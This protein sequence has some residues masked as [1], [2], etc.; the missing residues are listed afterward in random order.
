[1][2]IKENKNK[3]NKKLFIIFLKKRKKLVKK[4]P[5]L[6]VIDEGLTIKKILLIYLSFL[7]FELL[8]LFVTGNM[9][10]I[11]NII[12]LVNFNFNLKDMKSN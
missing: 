12:K 11:N 9:M 10:T 8:I 2:L 3:E 7:S 4:N 1:M 5:D 6:H